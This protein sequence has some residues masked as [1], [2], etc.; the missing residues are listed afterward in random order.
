MAENRI[1]FIDNARGF[2]ILLMVAG[3]IGFGENIDHFIHAFHMPFF[4][5]ISGY[6]FNERRKLSEA[7]I[8]P[9]HS[10]L[11]PYIVFCGIS[12]LI[13]IFVRGGRY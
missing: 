9:A 7:L 5:F 12:A 6:F 13:D 10:L 1:D 3:H 11:T 2:V 4:F 8:R